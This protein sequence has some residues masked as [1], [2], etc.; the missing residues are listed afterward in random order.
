ML[1]FLSNHFLK[2][3]YYTFFKYLS[4]FFFLNLYFIFLIPKSGEICFPYHRYPVI[5]RN[6]IE[7]WIN[8]IGLVISALPDYYWL[9][10]HQRLVKVIICPKLL[11]WDY[12]RSPFDMFKFTLVNS[13]WLDNKF[14]YILVVAHA[15][16]HHAGV[17]QISAVPQVCL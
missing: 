8:C 14:T 7:L 9:V 15:M 17:G 16:W 6:E 2:N 13:T 12:H 5:P 3:F 4:T 1:F 11:E 10:L